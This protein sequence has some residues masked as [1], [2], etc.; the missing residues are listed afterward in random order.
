MKYQTEWR[1]ASAAYFTIAGSIF[2]FWS[3]ARRFECFVPRGCMAVLSQPRLLAWRPPIAAR[4]SI[5]PVVVLAF[6]FRYC[7]TPGGLVISRRSPRYR[8]LLY[9][10][11]IS[12]ISRSEVCLAAMVH[13][14]IIFSTFHGRDHI[15]TRDA[16][17]L[18]Y[19]PHMSTTTVAILAVDILARINVRSRVCINY[20]PRSVDSSP[21]CVCTPC[22][23][24]RFFIIVC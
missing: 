5:G 3:V 22:V 1:I 17:P 20:S 15:Y 24:R 19:R 16:P 21:L 18:L 12:L 8:R 14:Y 13:R 2:D 9:Y 7:S 4:L 6:L 10:Q 23:A 11:N